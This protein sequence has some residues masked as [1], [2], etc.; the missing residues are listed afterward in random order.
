MSGVDGADSIGGVYIGWACEVAAGNV[1][2]IGPDGAAGSVGAAGAAPAGVAGGGT[3]GTA[4]ALT[5]GGIVVPGAEATSSN[6]ERRAVTYGPVPGSRGVT[7]PAAAGASATGRS[8]RRGSGSSGA[9][10]VSGVAGARCGR[11]WSTAGASTAGASTAGASAAGASA[12]G[13]SAGLAA[14]AAR[15]GRAC[16]TEGGGGG[17]STAGG[18]G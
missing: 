3:I 2:S 12:A 7:G 11:A 17:G 15:C 18:A 16:S 13:A 10:V 4:G 8:P 9:D 1:G 5:D 14:P 6:T